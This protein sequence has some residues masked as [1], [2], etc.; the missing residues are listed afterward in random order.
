MPITIDS[1][2]SASGIPIPEISWC[3]VGE[4]GGM[5]KNLF[6]LDASQ[7]SALVMTRTQIKFLNIS[8]RGARIFPT[9]L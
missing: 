9:E 5:A 4:V 7:V 6:F 2:S 1:S 3:L 8:R